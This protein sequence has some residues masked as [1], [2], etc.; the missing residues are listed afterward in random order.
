MTLFQTRDVILQSLRVQFRARVLEIT[1]HD[2]VDGSVDRIAL[3][4]NDT[5]IDPRLDV[6]LL[7]T[8]N[9]I[10]QAFADDG[11]IDATPDDPLRVH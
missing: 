9:S 5:Q 4:S 6:F 11:E 7:D 2:V 8:A 10:A 3:V 1:V